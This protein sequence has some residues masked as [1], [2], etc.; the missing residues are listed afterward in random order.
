LTAF[1]PVQVSAIAHGAGLPPLRFQ[2]PAD[3]ERFVAVYQGSL[4]QER[5]DPSSGTPGAVIGKVIG[6][7]R[8]EQL[9]S[10]EQR[11]YLRTPQGVFQLPISA[12]VVQRLRW[13]EADNMLVGRSRFGPTQ[14]NKFVVYQIA[15]P[16]GSTDIP[17]VTGPDGLQQV[18]VRVVRE[19]SFPFGVDAGTTVDFTE[20]VAYKQYLPTILVN[21]VAIVQSCQTPSGPC[22]YTLTT[23]RFVEGAVELMAQDS[24]V[25]HQS[26]P[27]RFDRESL[28]CCSSAYAWQVAD[29]GLAADG[30][31]LALLTL[32][33]FG[34]EEEVTFPAFTLRVLNSQVPERVPTVPLMVTPN[35]S[36]QSEALWAIVEAH[37]NSL[38]RLH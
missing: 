28:S 24:H 3:T 35:L 5:Q 25:F 26:F 31:V 9:F 38:V 23:E 10:D 12:G 14:P 15:R 1:D 19:I 32:N 2:P 13:G 20:T 7:V 6:G 33:V 22:T 30:R 27:L 34:F 21:Q 18:D 8:V 29:F 17:L 4:G 16:L 36:L 11:W 37:S